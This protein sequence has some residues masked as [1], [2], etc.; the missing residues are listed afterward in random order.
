MTE[1]IFEI[2]PH[3]QLD[4]MTVI[5]QSDFGFPQFWEHV[6]TIPLYWML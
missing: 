6:I 1:N 4:G 5:A 2:P 3:G